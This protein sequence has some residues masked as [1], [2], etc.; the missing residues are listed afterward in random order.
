MSTDNAFFIF[1][2]N[3]MSFTIIAKTLQGLEPMLAKELHAL[4]ANEIEI[5]KRAVSFK[6]DQELLY[7]SNIY[8]RTALKI[9]KPVY[10][11]TAGNEEILYKKVKEFNWTEL[12]NIDQSFSIESTVYSDIYT[13]TQFPSLKMKDAIVDRFRDE[14]GKRPDVDRDHPD[15]KF[16]LHIQQNYVTISL[17]SSGATLHKRGY[18]NLTHEAPMSEVLASGLIMLTGWDKK[19]LFYD[20]MC[21]SGTLPIE[22]ASI[23][24]HMAPGLIRSDFG[25]K[26]W[27]D[28]NPQLYKQL[29]LQA[30]SMVKSSP[31]KI[32]GSDISKRSVE[33]ATIHAGQAKLEKQVAFFVRDFH[34]S[35]PPAAKGVMIINPPYGERLKQEQINEFYKAIGNTLKRKYAG[36]KVWVFSSNL[37]AIKFIGLRPSVKFKLKNGPLDCAFHCFEISEGKYFRNKE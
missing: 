26:T 13:H 22:A 15:I 19:E 16:N 23:A 21:G 4:G 12:F 14:F 35:D 6:G 29:I 31:V 18:K 20:P 37:E 27:K 24:N 2:N 9:L 8:L 10:R 33:M 36:F 34:E 1:D 3:K 30:A 5:L 28:F 7:A 11:F 25:F 17:D 32:I